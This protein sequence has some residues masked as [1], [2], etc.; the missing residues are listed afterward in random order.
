MAERSCLIFGVT[1]MVGRALAEHLT[2]EGG[3]RIIG[4]S[5]HAPA[6]LDAIEHVPCDLNSAGGVREAVAGLGPI[7]H[8]FYATSSRQ[9]NEHENCLVNGA[10]FRN[11]VNAV[12]GLGGLEHL[13]LVTG[14]KHYPDRSTGSRRPIS[15]PP[16]PRTNPGFPARISTMSRR[17]FCSMRH[18]IS[19]FTGRRGRTRSPASPRETP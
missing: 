7:S 11:A 2:V 12:A 10:M 16:S 14:T 9:A 19:A 8:V 17:T 18:G 15:S 4:A 13:A 1:G 6:G 5:R 3:W